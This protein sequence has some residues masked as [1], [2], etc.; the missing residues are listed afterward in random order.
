MLYFPDSTRTFFTLLKY[1]RDVHVFARCGTEV[2][3]DQSYCSSAPACRGHQDSRSLKRGLP[4]RSRGTHPSRHAVAPW[5]RRAYRMTHSQTKAHTHTRTYMQ[6]MQKGSCGRGMQRRRRRPGPPAWSGVMAR[7]ITNIHVGIFIIHRNCATSFERKPN[8][9]GRR[10]PRQHPVTARRSLAP[11]TDRWGPLH[12]GAPHTCGE[13]R[14]RQREIKGAIGR[15]GGGAAGGCRAY[16]HHS[17]TA[18][19]SP[20]RGV[21]EIQTLGTDAHE[22]VPRLPRTRLWEPMAGVTHSYSDVLLLL[23]LSLY[24]AR[25]WSLARTSTNSDTRTHTHQP[26]HT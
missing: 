19:L 12:S 4:R 3:S 8:G 6:N 13:R 25:S 2:R 26:T 9:A 20:H 21:K 10:G 22:R 1:L 7:C 5:L 15:R 14:R 24:L 18:L 11:P 16:A 23:S 17:V